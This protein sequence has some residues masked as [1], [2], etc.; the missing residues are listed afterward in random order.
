MSCIKK[1]L[2]L[3]IW[4]KTGKW[5]TRK[6]N[7]EEICNYLINVKNTSWILN[8]T[9]NYVQLNYQFKYSNSK[10]SL[11]MKTSTALL[12]FQKIHTRKKNHGLIA[13]V[14]F[15]WEQ[16]NLSHHF[17]YTIFQ[18][19]WSVSRT[20]CMLITQLSNISLTPVYAITLKRRIYFNCGKD[21]LLYPII[22][23]FI[24]NKNLPMANN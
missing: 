19:C 3:D 15:H 4:D 10:V 5:G 21:R 8:K 16:Y 7:K 13:K 1:L 9:Y 6:K 11:D 14:H 22:I 20:A 23:L 24:N 12:I 17:T 18:Q 2:Y